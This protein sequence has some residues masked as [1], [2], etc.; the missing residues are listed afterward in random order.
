MDPRRQGGVGPPQVTFFDALKTHALALAGGGPTF[1]ILI[2]AGLAVRLV[3]LART[4][5]LGTEIVDEQHYVRLATSLLTGDGFAWGP[6]APTSLR[7]PL[8]PALL[9]AV[10]NVAGVG[11]LQIMRAA[12]IALAVATAYAVYRLAATVYDARVGRLAAV[13]VWLYP[14]LTLF[15]FLILTETLFTFLLISFVWLTVSLVQAPRPG[16][17]VLC[18][19]VLGLGALTRSVLW[20]VPMVLCPLMALLIHGRRERLAMPA[21]V[22]LGYMVV[23]TPWSI[24]NTQLQGV[25]TVVDTMGGLNLRMGNYEHT[26]TD[27]MWAAVNLGGREN[28]A[29]ALGEEFPGRQFTEGEKDKWAQRKAFAYMWAHPGVTLQ[30]SLIRFADFWGLEREFI[31]GVH[32][33]MF[34]PAPWV[35]AVITVCTVLALP[36]VAV[37]GVA[38]AWLTTPRDWRFHVLLLFPVVVIAAAHVLAFGHSRYHLPLIPILAIYGAAFVVNGA[39]AGRSG[40]RVLFA[41]LITAVLCTIWVYQVFVTDAARIAA[42]IERA[43]F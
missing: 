41:S 35:T 18:G 17:A 11:N 1:W 42:V 24:R 30:R 34:I 23:I 37:P 3:V 26:P 8:Y 31:A 39:S 13:A 19:L 7:P 32:K 6:G 4:G 5:A 38:G 2:A 43:G 10:W 28:W 12:Q 25:V 40:A 15:N 16:V 20:P 22:L 36:F 33:G 14:S 27:R 29:Y 21:L 9:A